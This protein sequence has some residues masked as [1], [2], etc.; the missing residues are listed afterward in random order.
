MVTHA[1]TFAR[2]ANESE[3]KF[4]PLC[5]RDEFDIVHRRC[6]DRLLWLPGE[7]DVV[8][9]TG[10]GLTRTSP[11][12]DARSIARY[13][14]QE[15]GDVCATT[16]ANRGVAWRALRAAVRIPYAL[17]YG[18]LSRTPS[19]SAD[20]NR[21]LDIGCAEGEYLVAMARLGWHPWGIELRAASA[22]VARSRLEVSDGHIFVGRVEE[23]EFANNSFD[24]VTMSHVLEHLEN[25]VAILG[26]I[27]RWLRPRGRLRIWVPNVASL[28]S[29]AFGRLWQGLDVP[30]HL[31]HFSPETIRCALE[32]S[33]FS[34]ERIVPEFGASSLSLSLTHLFNSV[35]GRRWQPSVRLT[36]G[37]LPL[38]SFLSAF[39]YAATLDVT[40][41]RL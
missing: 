39:G 21:I 24:L 29:R 41:K 5:G 18:G 32:T 27:H 9:C 10:C 19:P 38:A 25:P 22:D 36:Y 4:C 23:A 40:A 14:P 34:I 1:S 31:F 7:F 3:R 35:L 33:G 37:L 12:P 16:G 13:Y 15:Y 20:A 28:E 26:K 6:P 2:P 11:C 17:R 8:R 30:R